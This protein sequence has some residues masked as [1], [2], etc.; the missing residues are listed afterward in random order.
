MEEREEGTTVQDGGVLIKI[1]VEHRIHGSE[2]I[3][4]MLLHR[5]F[6][7][8]RQFVK[9]SMQQHNCFQ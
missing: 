6:Q 1:I 2:W 3:H 4:G 8:L 7:E 9:Q 5:L